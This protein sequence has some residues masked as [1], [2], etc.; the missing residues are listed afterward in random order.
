MR[1]DFEAH[2]WSWGDGTGLN[3][4]GESP[5]RPK[6]NSSRVK[7]SLIEDSQGLKP[8]R[9]LGLIGTTKVVP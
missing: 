8:A 4:N 9:F 6:G 3:W 2:F 7:F 5:K 1:L